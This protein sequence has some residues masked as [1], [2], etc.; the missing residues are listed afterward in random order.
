MKKV[1]VFLSAIALMAGLNVTA[2]EQVKPEVKDQPAATKAVEKK[3]VSIDTKKG[4]AFKKIEIVRENIPYGTD[5][6]FVFEFKNE[7]KQDALITGVQTSCGCTTASKPEEPVKPG[8]SSNISVKYDTKRVGQFTK[9]ITVS[10]NVSEPIILTIKGSVLP[11]KT[12][13][14]QAQPAQKN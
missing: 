12:D 6:M 7:S 8:K 4:I 14:E 10:S 13:G 5:D 2:Q 9:T 3:D 1:N 11:Q